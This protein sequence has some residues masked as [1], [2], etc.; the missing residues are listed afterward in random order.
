MSGLGVNGV[1][2]KTG[3]RVSHSKV[4]LHMTLSLLSSFLLSLP[5]RFLFLYVVKV[6]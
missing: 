6:E 3:G 2:S 5:Y 4:P 1:T